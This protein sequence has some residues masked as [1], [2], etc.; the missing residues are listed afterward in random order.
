[1]C[2]QVNKDAEW[3]KYVPVQRM[4]PRTAR[5][6]SLACE[7]SLSFQIF[8]PRTV[9]V[10]NSQMPDSIL[11]IFSEKNLYLYSWEGVHEI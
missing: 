5:S 1:M 6:H 3:Y 2:V 8:Y 11:M 9:S 4:I 7:E 10:N